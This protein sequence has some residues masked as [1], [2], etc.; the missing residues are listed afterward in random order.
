MEPHRTQVLLTIDTEVWPVV[1]GWAQHGLTANERGLDW[2]ISHYLEGKVGSEQVGLRFQL[3]QLR[4]YGLRATYFVE[5]FFADVAGKHRLTDLVGLI[6]DHKQ[7]IQ[8]HVHTEWLSDVADPGL[9]W[10]NRQYL[11]EYDLRQQT[12]ILEAAKHRLEQAGAERILAFRA[13]SHGANQATLNALRSLGIAFDLSYNQCLIGS[14]CQ[15]EPSEDFCRPFRAEG[16]WEL[17]LTVFIDFAEHCRP[18]QLGAC[19]VDEI[20]YVLQAAWERRWPLVVMLWHSAE[21]LHRVSSS[22]RRSRPNAIVVRRFNEVCAYLASN[23]D[24]FVTRTVRE[25]DVSALVDARSSGPIRSNFWR[26]GLRMAE[27][28]IGKWA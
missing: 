27:Q 9:P 10:G 25:L 12:I 7:E 11:H 2:Q 5:P 17:P 3:E 8:L 6:L 13:G 24:R 4:R 18:L 26:T 16:L 1:D 20:F 21:L 15:L 14:A 22:N 23:R 28:L 19:S